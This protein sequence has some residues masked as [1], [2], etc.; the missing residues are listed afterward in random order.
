MSS[1]F[2]SARLS[3]AGWY[4]ALTGLLLVAGCSLA[5]QVE[6]PAQ[7]EA[8]PTTFDTAPPDTLFPALDDTAAYT[9]SAWWE[10][11]GD[12]TLNTLIDSSLV[13]NL[14]LRRTAA[15]VD[16]LAQQY[17]IARAPLF[18]SIT[19]EG[20]ASRQEQPANVGIGGAIGSGGGGG[21]EGG[22]PDRFAFTTYN[23]SLALSYELDFWGRLRNQRGA[24]LQQFMAS[25]DDFQTARQQVIAQ[26]VATYFEIATLEQQIRLEDERVGLLQERLEL[27]EDRYDRGLVPSFELFGVQQEFE[28]ARAD[29]PPLESTLEDARGRLAVLLGRFAGTEAEVL[30]EERAAVLSLDPIPAGLPDD[31]LMSRP[32]V[33]ASARRL[34]ARRLE[35][36]VARASLLPRINLTAEGG[37]Q[38]GSL[39]NLVRYDQRFTN[40]IAGL[41]APLFQGGQLR[42]EV[43]AAR[44]RYAQAVASYEETLLTAFQEVRAALIAYEK[45]RAQYQFLQE[46]RASAAEAAQ[47]QR[48]RYERG[49]GD[50]IGFLDAQR[51]LVQ[52]DLRLTGAEEAVVNARIAV[53]RA[54]GGAWVAPPEVDDPR[55]FQGTY[56]P[57]AS[58]N[59]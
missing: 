56:Q 39:D 31:L 46:Q 45:Q 13:R 52:T 37:V 11:F 4:A 22:F 59:R 5:P 34:E 3:R 6:R 12:A 10:A 49:I 8:L 27:T 44:A 25:V 20:N 15:A 55:L 57:A 29:Q 48:R 24:T 40:L 33:R 51:A 54:L 9:A 16:E 38:S 32:D 2:T 41:T 43:R 21:P 53:H 17:R 19:G 23:L 47:T 26:T 36:G 42:A 58:S 30:G 35:I 50:Y 14:T 18:P 7:E 1:F 28:A